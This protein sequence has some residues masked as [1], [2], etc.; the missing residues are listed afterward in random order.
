[1]TALIA[2][3]AVW[4]RS[5]SKNFADNALSE[6]NA[7]N[8]N[9]ETSSNRKQICYICGCRFENSFKSIWNHLFFSYLWG[10]SR[11]KSKNENKYY[12]HGSKCTSLHTD[13]I[14]HLETILA[15][16]KVTDNNKMQGKNSIT[17][18]KPSCHPCVYCTIAIE[19]STIL[20]LCKDNV[21]NRC[22]PFTSGIYV[23]A[24]SYQYTC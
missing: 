12:Q 23:K 2:I 14:I 1:M 9:N 8:G 6:R 3:M 18:A 19:S 4:G 21:K 10:A 11:F 20:I 5:L 7:S 22:T 13:Y 17:T 24:Q 15:T 16:Y